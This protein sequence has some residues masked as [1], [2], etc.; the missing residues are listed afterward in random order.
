MKKQATSTKDG[1]HI[2]ATTTSTKGN[3]FK[4][5]KK[6]SGLFKKHVRFF[7]DKSVC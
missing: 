5:V 6:K 4:C 1:K 2:K 3:R 7:Q